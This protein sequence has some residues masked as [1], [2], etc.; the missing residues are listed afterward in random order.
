[1]QDSFCIY[2]KTFPL[3]STGLGDLQIHYFHFA[4]VRETGLDPIGDRERG[5]GEAAT[6]QLVP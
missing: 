3:S 2:V 1:M 6:Q 5:R 4:H